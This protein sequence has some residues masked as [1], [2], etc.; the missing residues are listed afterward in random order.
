MTEAF[1]AVNNIS[2]MWLRGNT[3]ILWAENQPLLLPE[4]IK[5]LRNTSTER[6]QALR[7]SRFPNKLPL[8][9]A[10]EILQVICDVSDEY[11]RASALWNVAEKL[12]L[13]LVPNAIE[14][15][16]G[17]S[18]QESRA[19]ALVGLAYRYPDLLPEALQ[20]LHGVSVGYFQA[21]MISRL[22]KKLPVKLLPSALKIAVTISEEY[23]RAIALTILGQVLSGYLQR[24]ARVASLEIQDPC[25]RAEALAGFLESDMSLWKDLA[26]QNQNLLRLLAPG[27]RK[28][29]LEHI[30]K[31]YPRLQELGGQPAVDATLQ[32]MRDACQQWP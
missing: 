7:L 10:P 31:L 17:I 26:Q 2:D 4:A 14:V 11:C 28:S 16:Y 21:Q 20:A 29:F 6:S 18:H 15:A 25:Y 24:Q 32:A 23:D 8:E 13:E 27:D 30:P 1:E 3:L 5:I 12:P 22:A 9:F 19:K